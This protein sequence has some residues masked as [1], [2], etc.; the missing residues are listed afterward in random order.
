M[1]TDGVDLEKATTKQW[2]QFHLEQGKG[3]RQIVKEAPLRRRAD[4]A[5]DLAKYRKHAANW[6]ELQELLDTVEP[7]AEELE[8][9]ANVRRKTAEQRELD[10]LTEYV[11]DVNA[12]RRENPRMYERD[13]GAG[14][15]GS[16]LQT[17]A[18]ERKGAQ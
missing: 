5:H 12:H 8:D 14:V 4:I 2:F 11:N 10:R 17:P 1:I 15:Y 6:Q 3:L 18:R 13:E 16:H 7:T 9:L